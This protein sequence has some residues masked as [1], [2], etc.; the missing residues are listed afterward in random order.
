MEDQNVG[1]VSSNHGAKFR[2]KRTMS[3]EISEMK[4]HEMFGRIKSLFTYVM[5]KLIFSCL[6]LKVTSSLAT[7]ELLKV[8]QR[9]SKM[10]NDPL[11]DVIELFLGKPSTMIMPGHE[12]R[13]IFSVL[14]RMWLELTESI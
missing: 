5:I 11:G 3:P 13:R 2:V 4:L 14:E 6:A 12:F 1:T 8:C 10:T 9:S 7:G